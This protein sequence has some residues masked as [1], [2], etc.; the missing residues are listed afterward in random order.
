VHLHRYLAEFDFRYSNREKLGVDDVARASIALQGAKGRRLMKQLV[1]AGAK[2][3]R[4]ER[5]RKRHWH[6]EDRR[7]LKLPFGNDR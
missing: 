3:E 5:Y 1:E 4:Y 7:Q 6:W 2:R